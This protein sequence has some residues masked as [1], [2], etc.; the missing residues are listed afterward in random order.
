MNT[1]PGRRAKLPVFQYHTQRAHIYQDLSH[2]AV[3]SSC[4]RE[5]TSFGVTGNFSCDSTEVWFNAM[6]LDGHSS[7]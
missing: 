2:A 3:R 1:D 4:P 7:G 5:V 6:I